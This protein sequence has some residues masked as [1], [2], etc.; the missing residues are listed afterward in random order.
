[1]PRMLDDPAAVSPPAGVLPPDH[2]T[3]VVFLDETGVVHRAHDRY[4]GI[5]CL[6]ARDPGPLL[7]GLHH[8][9]ARAGF[10]DEL[11][12]AD[13]DKARLR[14]RR[15]VV[16]L[17]KGVVDLVFDSDDAEFCCYIADRR[18]GDLT[19]RFKSHDYPTHKAYEWLAA[20][21]LHDLIGEREVVTVLADRLSTAPDVRFETDVAEVVNRRRRRLAVSSVCRLDSRST[22]GLQ[23]VDLLLGAAT[24]DLR[25]GRTGGETQK[26][27]LLEHLLDRCECVSFRPHGRSCQGKFKVELLAKP[28]RSRR[29]GRGG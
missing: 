21:V 11:H 25:Q 28:R 5:G 22:D 19:A 1:M 23:I 8:L 12:W 14:D 10:R 3:A 29:G 26:Q 16:E 20:E 18:N 24:L 15:D 6:K 7:Q 17:A 13:F 2:P 27:A 4:F 9:R